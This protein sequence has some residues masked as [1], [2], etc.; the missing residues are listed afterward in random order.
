[1]KI[2]EAKK[3]VGYIMA[4]QFVLMGVKERSEIIESIKDFDIKKYSLLD[5]IKANKMVA[6]ENKRKEKL[7]EY[8]RNKGHKVNGRTVH[9]ILADRLI[10]AVYVALNFEPNQEMH[11]IINDIGVACVP[12]DYND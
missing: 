4:W 11:V 8:H 12:V 5:L 1:M 2:K 10:A 6:S 3:I 9:M 7:A